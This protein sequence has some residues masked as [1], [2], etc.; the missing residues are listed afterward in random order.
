MLCSSNPLS[1]LAA[2][3]LSHCAANNEKAGYSPP[4]NKDVGPLD[5]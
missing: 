5:R 1:I 3:Q 4:L 2:Y